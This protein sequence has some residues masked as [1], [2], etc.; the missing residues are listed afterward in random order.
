MPNLSHLL[1]S[2]TTSRCKSTWSHAEVWTWSE[3]QRRL[4][5]WEVGQPAP[6]ALQF[7][8]FLLCLSQSLIPIWQMGQDCKMSEL[9][10]TI[11]GQKTT[12]AQDYDGCCHIISMAIAG[13]MPTPKMAENWYPSTESH[14]SLFWCP[15]IDM[16]H[17][18][19][20]KLDNVHL[21]FINSPW[22]KL[23]KLPN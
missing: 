1:L 8:D 13:E 21:R 4:D 5:W 7:L 16:A 3:E 6:L 12:E 20:W 17:G 19:V 2:H 15:S 22:I 9:G 18:F 11:W 10:T 23:T 14:F